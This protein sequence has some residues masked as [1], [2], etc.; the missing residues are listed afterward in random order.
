MSIVSWRFTASPAYNHALRLFPPLIWATA[1]Y[2]LAAL[3]PAQ[4]AGQDN[5]IAVPN[6]PTVSTPAQPVQPG[7][8]E[9]EWGVDASASERDINGLLKFGASKNFELRVTNNPFVFTAN[10]GAD[11]VGDTGVGFKYRFKQDSRLQ[12]SL[13]FMY[14]A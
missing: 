12:P 10:S 9:T 5:L 6:R 8:L 13:A 1:L 11:G 2:L 7:T 3:L 14:M 4:A